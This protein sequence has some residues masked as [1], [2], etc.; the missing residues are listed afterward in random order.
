M[1]NIKVI[2]HSFQS[3]FICLLF[4]CLT[5]FLIGAS[6]WKLCNDINNV[7][8]EK[9][10]NVELVLPVEEQFIEDAPKELLHIPEVDEIELKPI[11]M[12][13][14]EI[15]PFDAFEQPKL[16]EEPL[17]SKIEPKPK[18]KKKEI[19]K[20]AP[21]IVKEEIK[22]VVENNPKKSEEVVDK[23]KDV[24]LPVQ[25]PIKEEKKII[26]NVS[27]PVLTKSQINENS[28]YLA[29]VMKIFEKNKIYPVNARF[30]HIEGKIIVSFCIDK[31]GHTF[32][33]SAK[34]KTPKVL[35]E[36]AEELVKKSILLKPPAHWENSARIELP[37]TYKLH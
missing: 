9:K 25:L 16:I 28:R 21:K 4:S 30:N 19:R 10:I 26:P 17:M 22:E 29:K 11:E 32:N 14:A 36:A 23:V 2:E 24:S 6:V 1:K 20:E 37:I 7:N 5:Q 18:K 35:S 3:Y 15:I 8:C 31:N 13:I 27:K 34:T 12:S 33:V